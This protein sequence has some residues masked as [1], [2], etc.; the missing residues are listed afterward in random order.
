LKKVKNSPKKSKTRLQVSQPI[1]NRPQQKLA[2]KSGHNLR[3]MYAAGFRVVCATLLRL[4]TVATNAAMILG[5][6]AHKNCE[7][8]T[9]CGLNMKI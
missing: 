5:A 9:I 1:S 4:P 8:E 7:N 2:P 3:T 6:F